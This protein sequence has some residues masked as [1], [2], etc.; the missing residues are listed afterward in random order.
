MIK[1]KK[2]IMLTCVITIILHCLITCICFN[3]NSDNLDIEY[4][5]TEADAIE[6]GRIICK[7]KYPQFDYTH[8]TW[9]C[10]ENRDGTWTVFCS[11]QHSSTDLGGGYPQVHIKRNAQIVMLGLQV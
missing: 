1:N 9:H 6:I 3:I 7:N 2:T 11:P 5:Y 8:L 10:F 4:I